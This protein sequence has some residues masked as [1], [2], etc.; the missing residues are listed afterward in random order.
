M[1]K[2]IIDQALSRP[3]LRDEVTAFIKGKIS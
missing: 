1:I 2:A 3:E